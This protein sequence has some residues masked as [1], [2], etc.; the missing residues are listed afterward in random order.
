MINEQR[1]RILIVVYYPV[2]GI[3]TYLNDVYHHPL[4]DEYDFN[5]LTP[6]RH[7]SDLQSNVFKGKCIQYSSFKD[8]IDLVR[9]V[10][11]LLGNHKYDLLHSH[12]FSAGLLAAVPS[13]IRHIPHLMTAHD[14]FQE[15]QFKGLSGFIKKNMIGVGLRLIN[16]NMA[17]SNDA[18]DNLYE[19][20]P[21][22]GDGTKLIAIQN[23]IDVDKYRIEEKKDFYQEL[24]LP[25]KC[26]LFGFFGRFMKQ[27][28]FRFLV[29]A[30]GELKASRKSLDFRIITFGWG[31]FIREEQE[32][33]K[34]VDL[35]DLFLFMPHTDDMPTTVRGVDV[36]VMPSL[37]EACPLLPMEVMVSGVPLIA[38]NCI[39][40][41]EV[42]ANT[43][44]IVF[45]LGDVA[46]L[47]TAMNNYLEN[48]SR[49]H[50]SAYAFIENACDR[51]DV[52]NSARGLFAQYQQMIK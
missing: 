48:S 21:F 28:G 42:V 19:Y 52:A 23:G 25:E 20:F 32:Y 17:V 13:F 34:S 51:Y 45:E 9:Q 2:G 38:S 29:E 47:T 24:N 7:V 8:N 5:I 39:G 27:K 10:W 49:H 44:A 46:A 41:R 40:L 6:E 31:G 36:V 16:C 11:K 30:V 35:E 1:K 33:I 18:R 22:L 15:N 50:E 3:R 26:V 37:W 12:G 14:I 4:F 43:P